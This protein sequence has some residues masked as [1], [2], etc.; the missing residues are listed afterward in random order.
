MQLKKLASKP[1]LIRV[2]LDDEDTLKDYNEELEFYVW[3]KQPLAKF[4]KFANV[5]AESDNFPELIDFC[6]ELILDEAGKPVMDEGE[7]LP[8]A[9]MVRC[10]NKVVQQLGK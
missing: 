5:S 8:A 1:Q 10:I 4:I 3:D 9:V 2:V 6:A 7:V